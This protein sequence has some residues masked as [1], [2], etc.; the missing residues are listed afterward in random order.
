[1]ID[2]KDIHSLSDFQRNT[3]GHIRRLK[4]SGR[5]AVLTVNGK[6]ALVIQDIDTYQRSGGQLDRE[7]EVQAVLR[8]LAQMRAGLGRPIEEFAR[9]FRARR[10]GPRRQGRK[11]A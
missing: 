5:P 6:A 1:M 2:P 3:K 7:A 10:A 4:K 8:G 9:E 11:S